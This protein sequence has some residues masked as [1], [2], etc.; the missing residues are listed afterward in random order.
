M[1]DP[2]N[3][4]LYTNRAMVNLKLSLFDHVIKD[5]EVAIRLVPN[6]MKAIFLLAQ[7]QLATNSF[8]DAL[9]SAKK[10][11]ELCLEGLYLG[12]RDGNSIGPITDLVLKCKKVCWEAQELE[13]QRKRNRV[14]DEI[15]CLLEERRDKEIE[16]LRRTGDDNID[17]IKIVEHKCHDLSEELRRICEMASGE[18]KREVPDWCIDHITFSVMLDPVVVSTKV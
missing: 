9:V 14:L 4:V 13:N 6:N 3:P 15:L 17:E 12:Q 18:K 5:A 2:S 7:A 11:R 1:Y 8:T 10:A 16:S